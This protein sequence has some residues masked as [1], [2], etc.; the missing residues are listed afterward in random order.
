MATFF[1]DFYNPSNEDQT[2]F[3]QTALQPATANMGGMKAGFFRAKTTG[4]AANDVIRFAEFHTST[5]LISLALTI[6]TSIT[7]G[8]GSLGFYQSGT[9]HDGA[10]VSTAD[11]LASAVTLS[12]GLNRVDVMT[13]AGLGDIDRGRTISE[14]LAGFDGRVELGL[15][16][17]TAITAALAT[18]ILI[19]AVFVGDI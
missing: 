6:P 10:L 12:G 5:R 17:T 13:E 2:D 4:T 8:V 3:G 1:S 9:A 18:E 16:T 15:V 7:A 14:L 11:L 19:E